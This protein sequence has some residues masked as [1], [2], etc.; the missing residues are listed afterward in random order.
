M[1]K[2][3]IIICCFV[4]QPSFAETFRVNHEK[5]ARF[6][7]KYTY[8]RPIPSHDLLKIHEIYNMKVVV[9]E[10]NFFRSDRHYLQFSVL[11]SNGRRYDGVHCFVRIDNVAFSDEML[12]IIED[13]QS[14]RNRLE[15][16]WPS[17]R[18]R[19]LRTLLKSVLAD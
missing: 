4:V 5:I 12:F 6:I 17:Q 1:K 14:N 7:K 19:G 10:G 16:T 18:Y 2:L 11:L 3:I 13:C 8:I 9:R 15:F